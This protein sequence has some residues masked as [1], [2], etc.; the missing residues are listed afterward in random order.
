MDLTRETDRLS[1]HLELLKVLL[2]RR[3]FEPK[4][5]PVTQLPVWDSDFDADL[6][7]EVLR[8]AIV[9]NPHELPMNYRGTVSKQSPEDLH[10][11]LTGS[12]SDVQDAIDRLI[13]RIY[14]GKAGADR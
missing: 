2:S 7:W 14:G 3:V 12:P 4:S 9:E 1:I 11:C 5:V 10:V 6:R 13:D 8:E